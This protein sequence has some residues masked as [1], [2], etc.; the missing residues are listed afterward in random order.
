MLRNR[1]AVY[2]VLLSVVLL[3]AAYFR[4]SQLKATDIGTDESFS[5]YISQLTVT[6]IIQTLKKGDN[7]PLWELLSSVL[8]HVFGNSV[9]LLRFVSILSSL[10]TGLMIWFLG[11]KF[12]DERAGLFAAIFFL[13]SN[14]GYFI[15]HEA[16]V[17]ALLG[18]LVVLSSY[19]F[20]RLA[21]T[22]KSTYAWLWLA[23]VNTAIFYSHYL[24]MYI[25]VIQLFTVLFYRNNRYLWMVYFKSCSIVFL[26]CLPQLP[27]LYHRFLESGTSGTWVPKTS[28]LKDVYFMVLKFTNAP[29]L[30]VLC[31]IVL[32]VGLFRQTRQPTLVKTYLAFWFW[33]P[34]LLTFLLSF[35]VSFFL[36]RYLYFI[37]PALALLLATSIKEI[38]SYNKYGFTLTLVIFALLFIGT[39]KPSVAQLT[40]SGYHKPV[41]PLVNA[42]I[43][44]Q[45]RSQSATILS[46]LW[47]DKDL[48]YHA[49]PELFTS[50]FNEK[51]STS[52]F[53]EPLKDK[54][55]YP[56]EY[57]YEFD[58]VGY[59]SVLFIDD[60]STFSIPNN[61][62]YDSL[63]S[64]Y[65]L[66]DSA[67]IE[68]RN[69]YYFQR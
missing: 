11:K 48:V 44:H 35:K 12:I 7:P 27:M 66:Y 54:N 16:R 15:A 3:I 42:L 49:Y 9:Y 5:L 4:L 55:I 19:L 32:L 51:D 53:R 45:Q 22:G 23:L 37:L 30:T 20:L 47:L 36:D 50:Y 8:T 2:L 6:E 34:L 31:L 63:Q 14:F 41:Q 65:V 46:P 28:S 60:N 61:G 64:W 18:L 40:Y 26:L 33:L 17:Y 29:L 58:T 56:L 25:V 10:L 13:F 21:K 24:G 59:Q 68:K 69:L 67:I 1:K 62:I 57:G 38:G 39:F 43:Q 52:F